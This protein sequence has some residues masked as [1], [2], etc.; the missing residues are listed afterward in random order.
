M[1]REIV[2]GVEIAK[3]PKIVFET[4]A[5]RD[6]LASFWTP[7][8]QGDDT[9]GGE[10]TFGFG[11]APT[12]LPM[13]VE[14]LEQPSEVAWRST[15]GWPFWGGTDVSWAIEQTDDGSKVLFR[16]TGWADEMPDFDFGSVSLVW[17]TVVSHLKQ[18]V[19]SGGTANPALA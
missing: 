16:H 1:T 5:T 12:R 4:M 6:G 9:V 7:D 19:E 17:A 13:Q 10:L 15:G 14:R 18:V 8:V 11:P 2:L 3:E